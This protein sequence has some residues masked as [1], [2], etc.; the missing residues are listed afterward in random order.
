MTPF[1]PAAL[2]AMLLAFYLPANPANLARAF[3]ERPDYFAGGTL[4]GTKGDKLTLA[5]TRCFDLIVNAGTGDEALMRYAVNECGD[6]GADPGPYPLQPGPFT[7]I[8]PGIMP[9]AHP[10]AT[11]EPI[12]IAALVELG[13][14]DTQFHLALTELRGAAS[15][16]E[17]EATYGATI[18]G[19]D[20]ELA[21]QHRQLDAADPSDLI[22]EHDGLGVQIDIR[23]ADY[24]EPPPADMPIVPEPPADPPPDQPRP[25]DQPEL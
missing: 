8:D 18:A 12:V 15:A 1:D 6:G 24:D 16:G 25:P 21:D 7:P 19:A 10:L 20:A 2:L 14:H 17:L 11:F 9:P 5:D 4:G 22:R 23:E 13:D 3:R